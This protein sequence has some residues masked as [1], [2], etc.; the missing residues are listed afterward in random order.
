[1]LK[2]LLARAIPKLDELSRRAEA[3]RLERAGAP[4]R[5]VIDPGLQ[6]GQWYIV[7]GF[8]SAT[9]S[10]IYSAASGMSQKTINQWADTLQLPVPFATV[11]AKGRE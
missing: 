11:D 4:I 1:M 6:P 10:A 9:E 2:G 7:R 8:S 5:I 3:K